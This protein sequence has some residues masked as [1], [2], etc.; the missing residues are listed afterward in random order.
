[1]T[2]VHS[3]SFC[4]QGW[5]GFT[6]QPAMEPLAGLQDTPWGPHTGLGLRVRGHRQGGPELAGAQPNVKLLET[7]SH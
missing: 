7:D 2:D 5:P 1:M 3:G 6:P 4:R